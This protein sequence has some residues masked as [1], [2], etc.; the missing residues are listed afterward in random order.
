MSTM[1]ADPGATRIEPLHVIAAAISNVCSD[2]NSDEL[3]VAQ[4]VIDKLRVYGFEITRRAADW[5]ILIYV[6]VV[7]MMGVAW[8]GLASSYPI[9]PF[10]LLEPPLIGFLVLAWRL[11]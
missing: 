7:M 11:R 1:P 8:L 9:R 3:D 5:T 6:V 4:D 10:L 2:G